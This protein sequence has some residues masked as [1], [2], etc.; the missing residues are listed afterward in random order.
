MPVV[1]RPPGCSSHSAVVAI[2]TMTMTVTITGLA[3][4]GE[5][6]INL[7][8]ISIKPPSGNMRTV[9]ILI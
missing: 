7:V 1:A 4:F 6:S 3:R 5:N 8:S 2:I 9:L